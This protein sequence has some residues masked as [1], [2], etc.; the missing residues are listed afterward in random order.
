MGEPIRVDDRW[1]GRVGGVDGDVP[2][3]QGSDE[4]G[5]DGGVVVAVAGVFGGEDALIAQHPGGG[6]EFEL[7]PVRGEDCEGV[8]GGGGEGGVGGGGGGGG[9]FF[10]AQHAGVAD[11]EGAHAVGI[12][13]GDARGGE[14]GVVEAG[15]VGEEVH[16]EG[17]AVVDLVPEV[18]ADAGEVF[19][20]RDGEGFEGVGGADAGEHEKLRG[21]E[22]ACGEDDFLG[23]GDNLG[24]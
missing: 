1:I 23:G 18:L 15:G 4:R 10:P 3:R 24:G 16:S 2:A 19:D 9:E 21:L 14:E 17:G 22:G 8:F 7:G 6:E 13:G 11:G 20:E 5:G 12:V